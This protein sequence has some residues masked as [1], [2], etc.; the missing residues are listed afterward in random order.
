MHGS[1]RVLHVDDDRSFAELAAEHLDRADPEF[2]VET[3]D[4]P[5]TALQRLDPQRHDCIVS[6]HE[7]PGS[8]GIE[9]L[10][11]V[12]ERY[13]ELPFILFTGKGS[14]EIAS[15]AISAGVT[16]YLQKGGPETYELLANRI[17]NAVNQREQSRRFETLAD[18]VPGLSYR[19]RNTPDW[20]N[21]TIHG[22]VTEL[23]GYEPTAFLD[24]TITWGGDIMHPDDTE[25][26][27]D[28]VQAAIDADESFE[29]EYRI[30]TADGETRWVW[31]RGQRVETIADGP[32][33]LEGFITD[34]TDQKRRELALERER[35]RFEALFDAV[36]EP[37]VHVIFEEE[38]PVVQRVND[39][40][41][42]VFG[43]EP[44]TV[45]GEFLD[46][47]IVPPEEQA[48]ADDINEAVID[49]THHQSEIVRQTPDGMRPF[50]FTARTMRLNGSLEAVGTYVDLTEQTHREAELTRQNERLDQFVSMVSHDL[51]NPLNVAIG[52]L[53]LAME[54]HDDEDLELTHDA[55]MD[56][57]DM[58]GELVDE[59]RKDT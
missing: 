51:R 42:E 3:V 32:D 54:R 16:D 48:T 39:A 6:D 36:P 31:E 1:I 4:D 33:I 19:V 40:F 30:V 35:N 2:T 45:R 38:R 14:E 17:E 7:M 28:A 20:E 15:E 11:R 46:D 43:H 21:D 37:T 29:I 25:W 52:R 12:R 59:A 34:I 41:A 47:L 55:L 22:Q 57:A 27:F 50:L 44:D 53:E 56:M 49:G 18:L 10:H 8:T 24:G 9:L 5:E 23:T 26:V 58:I 13:P